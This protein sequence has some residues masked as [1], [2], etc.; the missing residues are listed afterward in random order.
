MV[1]IKVQCEW[2]DLWWP[3]DVMMCISVAVQ[4]GDAILGH[5]STDVIVRYVCEACGIREGMH[6]TDIRCEIA[7]LWLE[8]LKPGVTLGKDEERGIHVT[9]VP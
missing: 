3:E 8:S 9:T 2:C 5:R 7:N 1:K 6:A 4:Y